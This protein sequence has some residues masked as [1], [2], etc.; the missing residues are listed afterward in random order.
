MT[1]EGK[2]LSPEHP[3]TAVS[4]DSVGTVLLAL[5]MHTSSWKTLSTY[6][7][8]ECILTWEVLYIFI[9]EE[10]YYRTVAKIE[11]DF[12]YTSYFPLL[13]TFYINMVHLIQ[14]INQYG[15]VIF[16]W[17]LP[18]IL[19]FFIFTWCHFHDPIQDIILHLFIHVS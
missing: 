11:H 15:Y 4:S 14:R 13:L 18:F 8:H 1:V 10:L 6:I 12:P 17:S 7:I 9:L 5:L 2:A 3:I 19:I 16:N